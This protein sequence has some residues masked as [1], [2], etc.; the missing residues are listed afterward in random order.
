MP[1]GS[2]RAGLS[3]CSLRSARKSRGQREPRWRWLQAAFLLSSAAAGGLLSW[4]LL[5]AEDG[6][7]EVLAHHRESLPDKFF[8]VPCSEDYNSHR[9]FEGIWGGL[10]GVGGSRLQRSTAGRLLSLLNQRCAAKPLR[11]QQAPGHCLHCLHTQTCTSLGPAQK[12]LLVRDFSGIPP[13]FSSETALLRA[14]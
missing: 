4:S 3:L 11:S 9:R 13:E 2:Q 1:P 10:S 7:T 8:E 12:L 6:V 14:A 5:S